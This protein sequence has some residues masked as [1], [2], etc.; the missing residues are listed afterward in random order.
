MEKIIISVEKTST[1]FS[2]FAPKYPI[3][4]TGTTFNELKTNMLESINL[5]FEHSEVKMLF[6]K[7]D[8]IFQIID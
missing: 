2:A 5:Y 3:Y 8:L 6:K 1:G 4:T 7:Q